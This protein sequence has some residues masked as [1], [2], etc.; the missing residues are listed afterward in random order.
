[1]TNPE[2]QAK[3]ETSKTIELQFPLILVRTRRGLRT[4]DALGKLMVV[5]PLGWFMLYVMP[6]FA[7]AALYLILTSLSV[8]ISS[9]VAREMGR[10]VTPLAS[11]LIPGLNPFIPIV[12]GWIAL[13]V[14]LVVHEGAHG[15]QARAL[16]LPVKSAGL[17]LFLGLPIGAFV[18]VDDK[19]MEKSSL[20]N[21]GRVLAAGPGSNILT[22]AVS[23]V[24]L[25]LLVNSMVPLAQGVGVL[26]VY[27]K[28]PAHETGIRSGDIIVSVN[29]VPTP[30][31]Q[32]LGNALGVLKAG[33]LIEVVVVRGSST[34]SFALTLAENPVNRSRGFMG[35][36]VVQFAP[37]LERYQLLSATSPQVYLLPPTLYQSF[38]PYSGLLRGFYTSS[39]GPYFYD[40]ANLLFWIWF[41]NFNV[42]IFNALPIYPL[43]GGQAFRRVVKVVSMGRLGDKAVKRITIAVTLLCV[44]LVISMLIVP[45]L[46]LLRF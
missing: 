5:R 6:V 35:I 26:G 8:Y 46:D 22:A 30:G 28:Y 11:L 29:G 37:V 18:E 13:V 23:L 1:M 20:R 4:L 42:G 9:P 38:V 32:E 33:S 10:E 16:G 7:A 2:Q 24:L 17:L 27:E 36:E 39:I 41:V 3:Q 31:Q 25:I 14:A 12:Y 45:Y 44:F 15:V 40:A 21:A 43:D 34:K 19:E